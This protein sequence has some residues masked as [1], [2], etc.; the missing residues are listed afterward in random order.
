MKIK[1]ELEKIGR[2]LTEPCVNIGDRHV[3]SPGNQKSTNY[4]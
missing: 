4:V 2:D 3:G 1:L